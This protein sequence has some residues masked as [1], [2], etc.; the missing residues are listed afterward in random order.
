MNHYYQRSEELSK[1]KE[2]VVYLF[3]QFFMK[4]RTY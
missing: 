2:K 4:L 1:T 3:Q